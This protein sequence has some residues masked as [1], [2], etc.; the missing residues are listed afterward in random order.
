MVTAYL[1]QSYAECEHFHMD[2]SS[3]QRLFKRLITED[4]G[5]DLNQGFD[6]F[7]EKKGTNY[8]WRMPQT[9]RLMRYEKV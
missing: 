6:T 4:V 7:I 5:A 1:L 2:P 8:F 3:F 9:F